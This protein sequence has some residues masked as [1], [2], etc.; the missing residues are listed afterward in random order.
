M[1]RLYSIGDSF[2]TT[3]DP[4][5]GIIGFC[6]LY[7]KCKHFEHVSL[8]RPGATNFA[9]RL[10]IDRAIKD[11][12]DYVVIG[13]TSSDRFDI[14]LDNSVSVPWYKLEDIK[15]NGYRARSEHYVDQQN[16]KMVSDTFNN[17]LEKTYQDC[18]TDQ[19]LQ[20]IKSHIAYLHNYSLAS[21]KDYYI[22][23]DGIRK[24]I[25]SDIE[26]VLIPGWLGQHDWSWVRRLWPNNQH[27]PYEMPYGPADWEMPRR[28]T[29]THNPAWAHEEFCKTLLDITEDWS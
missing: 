27:S 23:S 24:L 29:N 11:G 7:C 4:E 22:I 5:D 14:V 16:I 13:L 6:E 18:L 15:Y 1:K 28:Y 2:M 17:L 20:A 10:Q 12:A 19:Q 25:S 3:D 9:I 8:A 21:Q 26:F